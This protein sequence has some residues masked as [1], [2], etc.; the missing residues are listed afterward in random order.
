MKRML[1][2]LFSLCILFSIGTMTAASCKSS[3]SCSTKTSSCDTSVGCG[4]GNTFFCARSQSVNAARELVGWQ[5]YINRFE[6]DKIYGA[7]TITPEFTRSFRRNRIAGFLFGQDYKTGKLTISGSRAPSRGANDWLAD[8]FGLAPDHVSE[9]TFRPR[10]TNFLVDFNLYLGLDEVWEGAFFRIHAPVVHTRW[11]LNMC[12]TVTTDGTLTFTAGYMAATEVAN[13]D[14]ADNFITAIAGGRT[15]G[16]M[17][18][19]LTCGKM[20]NCKRKK[21]RLS[22]VQAAF[23]WNFVQD[24]DYHFGLMLRGAAPTGN[25]PDSEFLFEPIVGNCNHWE[26]GAGLTASA[27][28]WTSDDEE[29]NF[30]VYLDANITH[31][32]GDKQQRV[33]DFKNKPN[34][35]YMLISEL[36][37]PVSNL[38]ADTATLIPS[39]QYQKNLF[40][41]INKICC[42]VDVSIAVQADVALKFTYNWGNWAFDLGYNLWARSG[43]KFNEDCCKACCIEDKKF[44]LKGDAMVY[45]FGSDLSA[46]VADQSKAFPLSATQSK[47]TINAGTNTT[48]AAN[49]VITD[50]KNLAVDNP[51]EAFHKS[52][53]GN[54]RLM[55]A[56]GQQPGT[57]D[58]QIRTSNP[59]K[60]ISCDDLNDCKGPSA[61][62]HKIFAHFNYAWD[63]DKEQGDWVPFIGIGGEAEFGAK[64]DGER[65]AVSQWGVWV[66]G[67]LSFD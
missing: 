60:F 20:S 31:L 19:A 29:T 41:A 34:S 23:G 36:G 28:L 63:D 52:G 18:E 62:S 13:A 67:G 53:L 7:I 55:S 9:V 49:F 16:D 1:K 6:M 59:P 26:L 48:T 44:A 57:A 25:Q 24:E 64:S 12:E 11:D 54:D 22:D 46:L 40:P 15:W 50:L 14:L 38:F 61:V 66:K 30:M 32:F 2:G 35:R 42:C 65:A 5:E 33:F 37:T 17:K 4:N 39:H 45:G 47:A 21:T 8:H 43:E 58:F 56:E 10:I 3:G 51:K 27:K